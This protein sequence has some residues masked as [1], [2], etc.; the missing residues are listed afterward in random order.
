M[1]LLLLL[2]CDPPVVEP[3]E[4][5]V[6]VVSDQDTQRVWYLRLDTR[7]VL[8]A[9]NLPEL[10]PDRCNEDY[11]CL[12]F[13]ALASVDAE[14]GEDLL[15]WTWMANQRKGGREGTRF[16]YAERLRFGRGG[17]TV[18]W[19][20]D[21]LDFQARFA[22]RTELCD[23]A[24]PCGLSVSEPPPGRDPCYMGDVHDLDVLEE[25]A[26]GRRLLLTDT[27]N[28]RVIEAWLPEGSTCA[29]V[30]AVLGPDTVSPWPWQTPND[31]DPVEVNGE[32][33]V[34]VT[35]RSTLAEER[36][37]PP[38]GGDG[39]GQVA[40]F[41][42]AGDAWTA[43]WIYPSA[44]EF[45]NSPHDASVHL[46]SDGSP[47]MVYAHS[48]GAGASFEEDWAPSLDHLGSI[49]LARLGAGV[50]RYA[51]DAVL[52]GDDGRFGFLRSVSPAPDG[53]WI[54]ADSGC[55]SPSDECGRVAAVRQVEGLDL[56]GL[57]AAAGSGA[58]DDARSWLTV[59]EVEAP[60]ES[61]LTCGFGTLYLATF[62]WQGDLG[63]TFGDAR[64][65]AT[66]EE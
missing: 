34:L 26:T 64:P 31:A 47:V 32:A 20:V 62:H 21:A 28:N 44:E 40:W 37:G 16:S 4:V 45:L 1:S 60:W 43:T 65:V 6:A 18:D 54:L 57:D 48:D 15:T 9:L 49:G 42:G 19:A 53:T 25:D 56:D 22:G 55:M 5:P 14:T 24:E 12:P 51:G 29:V 61:P 13:T 63:S 3:A 59:R 52:D 10:H 8:R 41:A 46:A 33:G 23:Q 7:E 58:F 30:E 11:A 17:P 50:P 35:F 27:D 66:C 39:R 38:A 2:A 36:G